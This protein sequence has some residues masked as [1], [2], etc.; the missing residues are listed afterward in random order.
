MGEEHVLWILAKQSFLSLPQKAEEETLTLL[1]AGGVLGGD[2]W[3][4][5]SY[6][7]AIHEEG[8]WEP[9]GDQF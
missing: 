4:C 6:S 2:V 9:L 5:C 1:V 3:K 8:D 7:A